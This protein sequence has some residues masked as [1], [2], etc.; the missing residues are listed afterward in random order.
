[1]G[2]RFTWEKTAYISIRSKTNVWL[3]L[4]LSRTVSRPSLRDTSLLSKR[5][6]DLKLFSFVSYRNNWLRL[7]GSFCDWIVFTK[8]VNK[9]LVKNK[10]SF[11]FNEGKIFFLFSF[12]Y[13]YYLFSFIL[14]SFI[15]WL[16][17]GVF[18]FY[19]QV[20]LFLALTGYCVYLVFAAYLNLKRAQTLL[21]ITGLVIF[22]LL[23]RVM[24]YLCADKAKESVWIPVK[25]KLKP[26]LTIIKW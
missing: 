7:T 25:Q 24:S 17:H 18:V 20:L 2:T 21:I 19:L 11:Y 6:F 8:F 13:F 5:Y 22:Y 9:I 10:K 14:F 23:Y 1:M 15:F 12:I 3:S 26:K 16:R 4:L